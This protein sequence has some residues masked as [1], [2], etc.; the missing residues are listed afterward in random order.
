MGS[1][2]ELNLGLTEGFPALYPHSLHGL[3]RTPMILAVLTSMLWR[4]CGIT[5]RAQS[6]GQRLGGGKLLSDGART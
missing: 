4:G 3:S 1:S 2:T 6:E 5:L